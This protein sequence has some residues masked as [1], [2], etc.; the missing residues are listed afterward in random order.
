LPEQL[1]DSSSA[2][3]ILSLGGVSA[4]F[5]FTRKLTSWGG[6][7]LGWFFGELL[8]GAVKKSTAEAAIATAA[9]IGRRRGTW[10]DPRNL[11]SLTGAAAG[12]C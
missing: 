9:A 12:W 1:V 3:R 4:A 5:V 11:R 6:A 2:C 10:A 8:Q 7:T